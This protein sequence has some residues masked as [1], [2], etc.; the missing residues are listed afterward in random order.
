MK[1]TEAKLLTFLQK[2]GQFII[3]IYQRTYS[4]TAKQCEQLWQ[5]ILRAG[6]DGAVPGH[7]V[8][9]I[10]YVEKGLYSVSSIPQLLV[11]DGQQRLTTVSLIIAALSR[12]L[13]GTDGIDGMTARKLANYHL[14]NPEEEGE[15]RYKLLLTQT[16]RL[17]LQRIVDNKDLPDNHS[18]RLAENFE[19][20]RGQIANVQDDLAAVYHGL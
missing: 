3:P 2:S 13:E 7:F 5:D 6:R 20:F 14:L 15:L 1:A 4:W 16:D 19:F 12:A 8:G 11:I 9:S 18:L 10:V 17:S